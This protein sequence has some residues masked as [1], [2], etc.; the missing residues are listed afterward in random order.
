MAPGDKGENIQGHI[1]EP[2]SSWDGGKGELGCG[3]LICPGVCVWDN[4]CSFC[5]L[6]EPNTDWS[7]EGQMFENDSATHAPRNMSRQGRVCKVKTKT[8]ED[9]QAGGICNC[10]KTLHELK[11]Y[12]NKQLD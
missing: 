11:C 3:N 4:D 7:L 8:T 2:A 6:T 10:V 12:T 9:S 1:I 5:D